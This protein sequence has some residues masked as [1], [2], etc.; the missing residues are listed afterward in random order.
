MQKTKLT[1]KDI[2]VELPIIIHN[3]HLLTSFLHQL[4]AKPSQTEL[5]LPAS[6]SELDGDSP[7]IGFYP[8][9]DSLDLSIDPFLEKN[10]DLLLDAIETH[11]TEL[12]NFQYH[13]RQLA[14]E[15]VYYTTVLQWVPAKSHHRQR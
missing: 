3:S 13:Q 4:P 5:D 10:C 2:L 11:Y 6:L 1:Y 9:L 15:Q 14:R 8:S 12:N 7:D